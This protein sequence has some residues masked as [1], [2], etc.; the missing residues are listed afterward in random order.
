MRLKVLIVHVRILSRVNSNV[1]ASPLIL[2]QR[3][4]DVLSVPDRARLLH[5]LNQPGEL[6]GVLHGQ[7]FDHCLQLHGGLVGIQVGATLTMG[8]RL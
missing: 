4:A 1:V 8:T 5:G 2:N 7:P 3:L 6:G